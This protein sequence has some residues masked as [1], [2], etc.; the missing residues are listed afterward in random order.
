MAEYCR[1]LPLAADP[2]SLMIWSGSSVFNLAGKV[3]VGN[4][5]EIRKFQKTSRDVWA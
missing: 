1:A 3:L 5:P 2:P 4:A